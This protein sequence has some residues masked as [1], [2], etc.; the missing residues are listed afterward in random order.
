MKVRSRETLQENDV[1]HAIAHPARRKILFLL[2]SAEKSAGD[3]SE[4]FGM[5]LSQHLK[6]LRVARQVEEHRVG[7]NRI[8]KLSPQPLREV[9]QWAEEFGAFWNTQ[10]DSLEAHLE[11]PN[12]GSESTSPDRSDAFVRRSQKR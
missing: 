7:R 12:P 11:F 5:S 3:L 10:L 9:W 1:F 4:P 2:K 8:Y 6:I